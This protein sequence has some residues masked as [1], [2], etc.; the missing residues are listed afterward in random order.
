MQDRFSIRNQRTLRHSIGCVGIGLHTGARVA[1]TLHPGE[2]DSGIVFIRTDCVNGSG[3][4]AS[5]YNVGDTDLCTA[6]VDPAGNRIATIEHLMAALSICGIDNARVELA[7]PE[8]PAMDGSAQPFVFLIECAGTEEQDRPRTV[9]RLN[10]AIEVQHGE[11]LCKLVPAAERSLH[12]RIEFSSPHVGIQ[13]I[14]L[15]FEGDGLRHELAPARTFGFEA[16]VEALRARG[17]ARG[18]SLR[19][20]VV[21][22]EGGVLNGEGLRFAD[23]FVR[24]KMLDAIGDLS[25]AGCVIEARYVGIRPS[26]R[27]NNLLLRRL[28][29]ETSA[30]EVVHGELSRA[31]PP[32]RALPVPPVALN[33]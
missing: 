31:A 12:C 14:S 33:S 19:N 11:S 26:H 5:H 28:F 29:E 6:L 3:I 25:L 1:L 4:R 13:E 24:H 21:I 32:M 27:L 17:L 7:G 16:D 2:A 20:A 15:A 9:I 30:F 8:V 23:E 22:G 18:G 10:R